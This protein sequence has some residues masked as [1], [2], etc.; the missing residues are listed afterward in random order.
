M[1]LHAEA[2]ASDG[3]GASLALNQT[4]A[5]PAEGDAGKEA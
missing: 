3:R 5:H 4:R 1:N 2:W